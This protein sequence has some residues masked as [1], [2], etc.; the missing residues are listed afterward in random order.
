MRSRNY[1]LSADVTA[2]TG[3]GD[4]FDKTKA[5]VV[6]LG[7]GLRFSQIYLKVRVANIVTASSLTCVVSSDA[8]GDV[9]VLPSASASIQTGL[10][11]ATSGGAFWEATVPFF[12]GHD[13]VA[14]TWYVHLKTDAGTLDVSGVDVAVE[15]R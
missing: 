7:D 4:A 6:E 9:I 13:E 14:D 3:I 2:A 11:T 8:D 1:N 12:T 15:V 5:A 10:T